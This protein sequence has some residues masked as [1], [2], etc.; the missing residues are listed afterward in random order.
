MHLQRLLA[1]VLKESPECLADN[2]GKWSV[3]FRNLATGEG[4][5]VLYSGPDG[6]NEAALKQPN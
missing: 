4:I 5:T 2:E 3:E 1:R 6:M